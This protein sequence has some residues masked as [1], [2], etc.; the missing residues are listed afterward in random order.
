MHNRSPGKVLHVEKAILT[1]CVS[2]VGLTNCTIPEDRAEHLWAIRCPFDTAVSEQG[3][4][5]MFI[6]KAAEVSIKIL[7]N[8]QGYHHCKSHASVHM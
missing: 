7:P 2:L 4:V 3:V 5:F 6:R 1:D 8:L